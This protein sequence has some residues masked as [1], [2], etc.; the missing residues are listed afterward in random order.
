MKK[1]IFD[2]VHNHIEIDRELIKIIDTPEFQRL[3]NIKQL[4]VAYH[5]FIGA[6]HNR[7]EHYIG[8]AYLCGLLMENIKKNPHWIKNLTF[9]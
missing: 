4:G 3:R 9:V 2:Q 7:F 8:V 1:L 5:V 6:S